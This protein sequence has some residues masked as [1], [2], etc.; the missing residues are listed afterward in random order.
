MKVG[1]ESESRTRFVLPGW[2]RFQS[3]K[4][5]GACVPTRRAREDG[6]N[7]HEIEGDCRQNVL[8][9]RFVQAI[10]L[11]SPEPQGTHS[12]RERAFDTGSYSIL[13]PKLRGLLFLSSRLQSLMSRL[14]TQMQHPARSLG[15]RTLLADG[16]AG[17][18][19]LGKHHF[20]ALPCQTPPA[21]L[22]ALW[23]GR[24]LGLPI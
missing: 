14:W 3:G 5:R 13:L 18:H 10:I 4:G 22:L 20:D 16:S 8:Q 6:I 17:T 21:T 7:A 24:P 9:M 11:R 2:V 15:L 12:L 1:I 23:A 19:L